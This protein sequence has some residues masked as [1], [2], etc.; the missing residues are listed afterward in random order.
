MK[1]IIKTDKAP[2]PI[3][4]YNQAIAFNGLVFV[5][6]QIAIHPESGNLIL[7]NIEDE[8]NQVLHNVKAV[9]AASGTSLEKVLKVSVFVKDI[10][11]FSRINAVY[12]TYFEEATAPARELVQ[13][14]ELP[15]FVNIEISVIAAQ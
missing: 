14:S 1:Q 5:S 11:L 9:L 10:N 15:R 13:V 8:T 2:L 6:G 7:N 4:P 12:A 3:G